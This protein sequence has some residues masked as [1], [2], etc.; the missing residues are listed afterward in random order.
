MTPLVPTKYTVY[1]IL[2]GAT[3]NVYKIPIVIELNGGHGN[4]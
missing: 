2:V 1:V 4:E 3:V